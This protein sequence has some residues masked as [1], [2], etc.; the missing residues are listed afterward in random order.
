MGII[1]HG[2]YVFWLEEARVAFLRDSGVFQT[3]GLDAINYPVLSLHVDYKK[4]ILFEDEVTV[5]VSGKI[6]GAKIHFTYE[7]QTKRFTEP[8]AFGKSTH[9]A[10][11][12]STKR[13]I[14]IP[15]PVVQLFS[16]R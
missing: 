10:M 8:A 11:D 16:G 15:Q 7:I 12:M 13:P 9:V 6:E 5:A 4:S 3:A 14:R 1:H 2:S